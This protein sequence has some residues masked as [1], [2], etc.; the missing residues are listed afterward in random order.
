MLGV[1]PPLHELT[2]STAVRT[3]DATPLLALR[4][5][6]PTAGVVVSPALRV[7]F[8]QHHATFV[9]ALRR[10]DFDQA[11]ERWTANAVVWLPGQPPCYGH[12]AIRR[13]LVS[14]RFPTEGPFRTEALRPVLQAGRD[15]PH[16]QRALDPFG[17][18]CLAG[19]PGALG[20]LIELTRDQHHCA[21]RTET[22]LVI[23][24]S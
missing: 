20:L 15:P 7:L 6:L 10:Y 21:I 3:I 16:L 17:R 4:Q 13:L 12:Q 24:R 5:P 14:D 1:Q 8:A 9:Q 2:R 22:S 19:G 18:G 11:L 23:T